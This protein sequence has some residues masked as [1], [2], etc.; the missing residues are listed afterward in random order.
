MPLAE[1][2]YAFACPYCF[3][4]ISIVID[5]TGGSRQA[6]TYDCEICCRPIA[7]HLEIGIRGVTSFGAEQES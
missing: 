5:Y 3:T 1:D 7:I 4:E 2:E 6:F